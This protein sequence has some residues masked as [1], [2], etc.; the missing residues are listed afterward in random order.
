MWPEENLLRPGTAGQERRNRVS[1]V[2]SF[3]DAV[4]AR[5]AFALASDLEF[6]CSECGGVHRASRPQGWRACAEAFADRWGLHRP[7]VSA[8][9]RLP[10]PGEV[11]MKA[12]VTRTFSPSLADVLRDPQLLGLVCGG[13]WP[14]RFPRPVPGLWWPDVLAVE[15]RGIVP[16]I[17]QAWREWWE[18]VLG[19]VRETARLAG[20]YHQAGTWESG[21]PL[22][23]EFCAFLGRLLQIPAPRP[24]AD[25]VVVARNAV[26]CRVRDQEL[27]RVVIA[28]A[29]CGLGSCVRA[30][31]PWEVALL[32]PRLLRFAEAA[33]GAGMD[34]LCA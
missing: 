1:T 13:P 8:D 14:N 25:D 7:K 6:R 34:L 4:S 9:Q 5:A 31:A 12:H 11:R 21:V 29:F 28:V 22:D 27:N 26:V 2:L 15:K 19:L 3:P 32:V 30:V 10:V 17:H 24:V 20:W 33:G 18:S 16:V 23:G